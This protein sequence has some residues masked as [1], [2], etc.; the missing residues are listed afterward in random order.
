MGREAGLDDLGADPTTA[1]LAH[2]E[3]EGHERES[4]DAFGNSEDLLV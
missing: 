4:T 1:F 2:L 3:I